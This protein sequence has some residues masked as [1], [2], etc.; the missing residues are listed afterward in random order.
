M[1]ANLELFLQEKEVYR[2]KVEEI[3]STSTSPEDLQKRLSEADETFKG[4]VR[5]YLTSAINIINTSFG[6]QY[7]IYKVGKD[8]DVNFHVVETNVR[9]TRPEVIAEME[10]FKS[11]AMN[12]NLTNDQITKINI[13]ME[14]LLTYSDDAENQVDES[15]EAYLNASNAITSSIIEAPT[16][17]NNAFEPAPSENLNFNPYANQPIEIDNSFK[18]PAYEKKTLV[19]PFSNIYGSQENVSPNAIPSATPDFGVPVVP[20]SSSFDNP[21]TQNNADAMSIF[22]VGITKTPSYSQN[23]NSIENKQPF[24]F[25]NFD[26]PNYNVP[27]VAPTNLYNGNPGVMNSGMYGAQATDSMGTFPNPSMGS[28]SSNSYSYAQNSENMETRVQTMTNS[29]P[30]TLDMPENP[31]VIK[32]SAFIISKVMKGI[33]RLPITTLLFLGIIVLI[34]WGLNKANLLEEISELLGDYMKYAEFALVLFVT[35]I[36]SSTVLDAIKTKTKYTSKHAITS[37][38]LFSGALYGIRLLF[39][40]VMDNFLAEKL[41]LEVNMQVFIYFAAYLA[42][43]YFIGTFTW[44]FGFLRTDK[45]VLKKKHLNIIE[46]LGALGC[47]YTLII[48]A[49]MIGCTWCGLPIVAEKVSFIYDYANLELIIVIAS[50]VLGLIMLLFSKIE[51]KKL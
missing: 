36:G 35:L 15:K 26:N 11:Q 1:F 16:R 44:L 17:E 38:V 25:Q 24:A 33:L 21:Q 2:Q 46:M 5:K 30:E 4:Q 18:N 29:S 8:F 32:E 22:G 27:P 20:T 7:S 9:K 31:N 28:S 39:P 10:E 49:T 45:T 13:A 42:L 47:I 51:E 48:P 34:F 37:L 14:V 50:F 12:M 41:S 3:K 43:G 23:N 6:C 40:Y 19:D